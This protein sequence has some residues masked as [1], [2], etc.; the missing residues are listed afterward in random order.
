MHD[1]ESVELLHY[2]KDLCHLFYQLSMIAAYKQGTVDSTML[3]DLKRIIRGIS[4][5]GG[6]RLDPT[7]GDGPCKR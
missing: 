3:Q 2:A 7:T 4:I 1:E 5:I 6:V